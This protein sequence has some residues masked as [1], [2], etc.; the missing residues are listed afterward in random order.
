MNDNANNYNQP[1]TVTECLT[2]LQAIVALASNAGFSIFLDSEI[3]YDMLVKFL[4]TNWYSSG[5]SHLAFSAIYNLIQ[6]NKNRIKSFA[7]AGC[8]NGLQSYYFNVQKKDVQ[9]TNL[10]LALLYEFGS[11][12]ENLE[13][14]FVKEGGLKCVLHKVDSFDH[15][16]VFLINFIHAKTKKETLDIIL[17]NNTLKNELISPPSEEKKRTLYVMLMRSISLHPNTSEYL[18][19]YL[20]WYIKD[21]TVGIVDACLGVVSN[22]VITNFETLNFEKDLI[23]SKILFNIFTELSKSIDKLEEK[24]FLKNIWMRIAQILRQDICA[25]SNWDKDT[26]RSLLYLA[27]KSR[28]YLLQSIYF[29]QLISHYA[30]IFSLK[31]TLTFK[32]EGYIKTIDN[33]SFVRSSKNDNYIDKDF[34]P[35]DRSY[36]GENK[37]NYP[38]KVVFKE[39]KHIG[40][41]WDRISNLYKEDDMFGEKISPYHVIRGIVDDNPLCIVLSSIAHTSQ[42]YIKSLFDE[43]ESNFYNIKIYNKNNEKW[44]IIKIDDYIPCY[45][46][47]NPVGIMSNNRTY[48]QLLIEKAF[49]KYQGSYSKL[50]NLDLESVIIALTGKAPEVLSIDDKLTEEMIHNKIMDA[51][52]EKQAI[53]LSMEDKDYVVLESYNLKDSQ[54]LEIHDPEGYDKRL[55]PQ[56][57][58]V[59]K[60][61]IITKEVI[62]KGKAFLFVKL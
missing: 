40:I 31:D 30:I 45:L 1:N 39:S 51:K 52:L 54:Y 49:A 2:G 20:P 58:P 32:S 4:N 9:K 43:S 48:W 53:I 19:N 33:I 60:R 57:E 36:C 6:L 26:L 27:F 3:L 41:M 24:E 18:F 15:C 62:E 38:S 50:S 46:F 21:S 11:P 17:S 23:K 22:L 29:S 14:R 12:K 13:E 8:I 25:S 7:E 47:G 55:L 34:M 28:E 35:D 37:L 10:T 5:G 59:E 44:Q 56:R 61:I 16:V 42:P